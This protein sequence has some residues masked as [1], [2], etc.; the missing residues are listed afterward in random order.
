MNMQV[1]DS[2]MGKVIEGVIRPTIIIHMYSA[3]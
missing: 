1:A 2:I 3:L